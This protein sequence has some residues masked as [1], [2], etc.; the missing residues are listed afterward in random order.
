[1]GITIQIG[2]GI[3]DTFCQVLQKRILQKKPE[4]V[5]NHDLTIDRTAALSSLSDKSSMPNLAIY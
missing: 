2:I 1:M 4:K 3:C 5:H